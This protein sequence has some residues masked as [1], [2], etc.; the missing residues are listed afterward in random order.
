MDDDRLSTSNTALLKS[1]ST[2]V[3]PS[4]SSTRSTLLNNP[5]IAEAL[6]DVDARRGRARMAGDRRR[7]LSQSRELQGEYL[8]AYIHY[9]GLQRIE[10]FLFPEG[11]LREPL[12]N[13]IVHKD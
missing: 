1:S 11:A 5:P 3:T 7:T 9:E 10:R 4:I 2:S 6:S 8:K 13:A 12:L